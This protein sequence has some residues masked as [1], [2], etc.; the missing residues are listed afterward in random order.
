[1]FKGIKAKDLFSWAELSYEIKKGVSQITGWNF[2]D[3]CSEG[4]GK[5]AIINILCWIVYGDIP[6]AAKADEVIREGASG[7]SGEITLNNGYIIRR[8]RKPND[9]YIVDPTGKV[10]RGK[11]AKDTQKNI[12]KLIGMDF[13]AFCQTV[14]FAQNYPN[15]FVAA[16]EADKA[17]ILSQIQD[18]TIFDKARNKTQSLFK[19]EETSR[20]LLLQQIAKAEADAE[21][22]KSNAKLI[23]EFVEKFESDKAKKL[24][25]LKETYEDILS[26]IENTSVVDVAT[27]KVDL[28]GVE[29]MLKDLNDKK[30]EHAATIKTADASNRERLRA[31]EHWQSYK[32]KIDRVMAKHSRLFEKYTDLAQ[33]K[34]S[35]SNCP[36]C[37]QNASKEI[38]D[39][40]EAHHK[41][42]VEEA[43]EEAEQAIGELNELEREQAK[44]E[45]AYKAADAVPSADKA[46][47]ILMDI[48]KEVN[49]LNVVRRKLQ[50]EMMTYQ[51]QETEL[52]EL[53]ARLKRIE[54]EAKQVK[55]TDCTEELAQLEALDLQLTDL[56]LDYNLLVKKRKKSD[57]ELSRLEILKTGYREVKQYVFQSL[58]RDLSAKATAFAGEL[59]EVPV[60]IE[61]SNEEEGSVSKIKTLVTMDGKERSLGLYS[62]GQYR[63]IEL[64]VDLA[65]AVIVGNRSLNPIK[66]RILDEPMKDLSEQ[67]MEKVI[68]VLEKLDGPTI[69]IEH[70]SIAK[71][72]VSN[73]FHA[74]YRDGVSYAAKAV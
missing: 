24:A 54:N 68:K 71:S 22:L 33:L 72:I 70:N 50:S 74:E 39:K 63:R 38:L 52:K 41:A 28:Q 59:F 25:A 64:A 19:I 48:E 62:G 61:F 27:V 9:V 73:T 56:S 47:A 43:A 29:D 55:A 5:S 4:S 14:Y 36:T 34:T 45:K 51:R 2:D 3:N 67:S 17:A 37:G 6:K 13:D 44:A 32:A 12:N 66:F 10:H 20:N 53:T 65:L 1:M 35:V 42:L 16:N 46:K 18:L 58:L 15:K 31:K 30:V 11:D 57:A 49:D 21:R 60:K 7:G 40:H 8:S 23:G 26:G 69:I